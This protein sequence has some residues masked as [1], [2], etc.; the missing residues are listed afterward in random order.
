M[1][2]L[3]SRALGNAGAAV[4]G[5]VIGGLVVVVFFFLCI[6]PI[7]SR[8][9]RQYRARRNGHHQAFDPESGHL[10][11]HF[12]GDALTDSS[13][14]RPRRLPSS[15]SLKL[16]ED[17][18]D[19]SHSPSRHHRHHVA[20]RGSL[21]VNDPSS[22]SPSKNLSWSS[23]HE[24][25]ALADGEGQ[26]HLHQYPYPTYPATAMVAPGQPIPP[27]DD[28]HQ[29]VPSSAPN[30]DAFSE[31]LPIPQQHYVLKHNS[32]DYYDPSIPSEAFGMVPTP[33][34][35]NV[36]VPNRHR[37]TSIT[38]Q[39]KHVFHRKSVRDRTTSTDTN[40]SEAQSPFNTGNTTAS[41]A[42]GAPPMRQIT[43]EELASSPVPR[44]PTHIISPSPL[45][46][47][48]PASA[49]AGV[50]R[51]SSI[52]SPTDYRLKTSPSP[53]AHPAPGTV[54]PM[55]IM[56]ASTES[57][58]WH[59][60]E[61]QLYVSSYESPPQLPS[62]IEQ[63][64]TANN[65]AT[66]HSPALDSSL[67]QPLDSAQPSINA[68]PEFISPEELAEKDDIVMTDIPSYTSTFIPS[69]TQQNSLLQ[70][71]PSRRPSNPSE[72]STPFPGAASTD[73]S[74]HNTPSTLLDS[75]SPESMHSSDFRHSASPPLVQSA[76][77]EKTS[78]F[79][80]DELGCNQTFDQPHKLKHEKKK[81]FH[82][83]I[84]GCDYSR[85]G[86]KAFP[87]KDNW[88]RHMTKIHNMDQHNLPEPV[89]VE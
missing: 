3:H 47:Q 43:D 13:L 8:Q 61:H 72:H 59:R 51:T 78:V 45:A 1:K 73:A 88:K 15:D 41:Y 12:E 66:S 32:E 22:S 28:E 46:A 34:K 24:G 4:A 87:R 65:L 17:N 60:T 11:G 76:P 48:T 21:A 23:T 5:V 55:D 83:A 82:C 37:S 85:A 42:Q 56:P 33:P 58:L 29:K 70:V 81:K 30:G 79:R 71:A 80:C 6:W 67:Q 9:I 38:Q 62:F 7:I 63:A 49:S 54:N 26:L 40:G 68:T 57:E 16:P 77:S 35:L 36:S 64:N 53:P 69:T 50:T 74:S 31:Q 25:R 52:S 75:P 86:G 44:S 14:D 2:R 19:S 89:E 84:Q 20:V 39:M 10:P 27:L 18:D